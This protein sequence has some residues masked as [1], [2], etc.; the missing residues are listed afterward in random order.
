[1]HG[2]VW[3]GVG[4]CACVCVSV[5]VCLCVQNRYKIRVVRMSLPACKVSVGGTP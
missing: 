5:Y 4:G 3:V 1:M 2:W